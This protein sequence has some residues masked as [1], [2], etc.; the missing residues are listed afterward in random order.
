[1]GV[2]GEERDSEVFPNF[3]SVPFWAT[4]EMSS[5]L[6]QREDAIAYLN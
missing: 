1:M 3:Y 6:F 2:D 4:S 5:S